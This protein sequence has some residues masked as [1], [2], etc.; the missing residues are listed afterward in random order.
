MK[1]RIRDVDTHHSGGC[2]NRKG[3]NPRLG[4]PILPE[5]AACRAVDN[6]PSSQPLITWPWPRTKSKGELRSRE[7]CSGASTARWSTARSP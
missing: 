6:A 3:L 4:Q 5:L 1:A 7:D 2:T